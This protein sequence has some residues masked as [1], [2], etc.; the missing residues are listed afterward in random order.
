LAIADEVHTMTSLVGFEGLLRGLRVVTYGQPFYAGWGLTEDL[1]A[2]PRRTR[3]LELDELVCGV[4]LRYPRYYSY[5][6]SAFTTAD[7]VVAELER[8]RAVAPSRFPGRKVWWR[9]QL[10]RGLTWAKGVRR[11]G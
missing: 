8:E 6:A 9:R 11:A 2:P 10:R 4:L 1:C 5:H 7:R 3:R